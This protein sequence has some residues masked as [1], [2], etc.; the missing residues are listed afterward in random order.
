MWQ[1]T[2]MK[3]FSLKFDDFCTNK[4]INWLLNSKDGLSDQTIS[5]ATSLFVGIWVQDRL[6]EVGSGKYILPIVI[7]TKKNSV[8]EVWYTAH[9]RLT[10]SWIHN[11]PIVSF[12]NSHWYVIAW[13]IGKTCF[14]CFFF[15]GGGGVNYI[16]VK[17]CSLVSFALWCSLTWLKASWSLWTT[18]PTWQS[19]VTMQV[20]LYACKN[21]G[22]D[23]QSK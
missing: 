4:H 5:S 12:C 7:S 6:Y 23:F 2:S 11:A 9:N 21:W 19:S 17:L 3:I 20:F 18:S 16:S 15:L 14:F 10:I 1:E 13:S 8:S 22:R